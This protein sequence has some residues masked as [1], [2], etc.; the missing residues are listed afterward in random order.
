LAFDPQT[1]SQWLRRLAA[2]DLRVFEDVRTNPAATIPAVLVAG[3]SIFLSGVGGWLWWLTKDYPGRGDI[4]VESA[5]FGSL[6]AL[7]L[8]GLAWL[9]VTFVV[10]TQVLRERVYLEQLLRV[11]GLAMLPMA[12]SLLMFIPGIT[13][14]VGLAS[15]G[16]TFA[17]TTIA[18]QSVTTAD[19]GQVLIANGAGFLL[20]A[21]VL[22]LVATPE[23]ALAPGIFLYAVLPEV[24][25]DYVRDF[26]DLTSVLPAAADLLRA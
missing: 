6:L 19:A 9:L 8:W 26:G 14:G 23:N 22:S 21:A 7:V 16:L 5:V 3:A 2:L 24:I 10:L 18:I 15:L 1:V 4:L 25:G 13:L 12:L 11:M 20:W 17:L